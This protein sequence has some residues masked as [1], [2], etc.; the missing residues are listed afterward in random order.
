MKE[1]IAIGV[2]L[3]KSVFPLRLTAPSVPVQADRLSG[4]RCRRGGWI[5]RAVYRRS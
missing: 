1:V 5:L 3:A 4:R 2:D